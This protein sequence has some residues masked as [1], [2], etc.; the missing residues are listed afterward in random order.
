MPR[1][2]IPNTS[3]R[4]PEIYRRLAKSHEVIG[5]NSRWEAITFDLQRP[6]PYRIL[7]FILGTFAIVLAA[8]RASKKG[9]FDLVLCETPQHALAGVLAARLL[10]VPMVWDSHGNVLLFSRSVGKGKWFSTSSGALERFIGQSADI[11][12]TVGRRDTAAYEE[13][14]IDPKKIRTF[15][16]CIDLQEVKRRTADRLQSKLTRERGSVARPVVLFF[17][18]FKYEPNLKALHFVNE[19]LAPGLARA[20]ASCTIQIAGR[21][22]PAG[23]YHQFVQIL[24]FVPDIYPCIAA[25]DLGIVPVWTGVGI[26]VKAL[27]I[28]AVGTPMVASSFAAEGIPELRDGV[29]ALLADTPENFAKRVAEALSRLSELQE[30]GLRGQDLVAANYDWGSRWR[31]FEEILADAQAAHS[32]Q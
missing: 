26:L 6:R 23:E 16:S 21:D 25:A 7:P 17:G 19:V 15:P 2:D 32:R 30:M 1:I 31:L 12:I 29:H 28:L 3:E 24:G 27:D 4:T 11:L 13:M 10:D 5:F 9:R 8:L 14:G 20:G 18:S 22:I